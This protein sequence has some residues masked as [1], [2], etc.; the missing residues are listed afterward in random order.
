MALG[1][2][3]SLTLPIDLIRLFHPHTVAEL[4]GTAELRLVVLLHL[5]WSS[6]LLLIIVVVKVA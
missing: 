3:F 1:H 2:Y 6:K 4:T 5:S